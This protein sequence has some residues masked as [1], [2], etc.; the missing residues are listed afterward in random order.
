MLAPRHQNGKWLS[1]SERRA[2]RVAS[3]RGRDFDFFAMTAFIAQK[4][5]H[6]WIGPPGANVVVE[7]R[8]PHD[9]FKRRSDKNRQ[10][11]DWRHT[12]Q[13]GFV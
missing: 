13:A 10:S 4:A 2:Y 1:P 7:S 12:D 11:G 3:R 9:Q 5:I 8:S 6:E